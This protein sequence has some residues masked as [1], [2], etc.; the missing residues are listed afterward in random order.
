MRTDWS[1]LMPRMAAQLLPLAALLPLAC[2]GPAPNEYLASSEREYGVSRT[3][4]G[5][6]L[7]I[8]HD[9]LLAPNGGGLREPGF[10]IGVEN[11]HPESLGFVPDVGT[12]RRTGERHVLT[13]IVRYNLDRPGDPAA[14][15]SR[16]CVLFSLLDRNDTDPVR[17]TFQHCPGAPA[18]N[19]PP[20]ANASHSQGVA[21]ERFRD[22][23]TQV[24]RAAPA[25]APFT[26]I[27]V[28]VMGWNTDQP[29]ALEN[30]DTITGNLA[31]VARAHG[32][33]FRPL[34]IGVSWPSQWTLGE[35]SVVPDAVVRG[36][37]FPFK[38]RDANDTGTHVLRDL[39]LEG[40]LKAREKAARPMAENAPEV[41]MIGH[42]FG[43]WALR[44]ALAPAP[45]PQAGL[46]GRARLLLAHGAFE[47]KD[48]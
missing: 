6:D 45:A 24:L 32:Q 28:L 37:S 17:R 46:G 22:A 13:H 18:Y 12:E 48:L 29:T 26:H 1:G 38:R 15:G 36:V 5:S 10:L 30:F 14:G 8:Y 19:P 33:P 16:S 20:G 23:L 42:S 9:A 27:L 25:G 11:L 39:V 34:V 44:R 47:F 31:D 7:R 3:W 35:W 2:C 41:V 4:Y 43:A 21:I 40:V